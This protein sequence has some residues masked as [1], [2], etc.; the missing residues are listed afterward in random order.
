MTI[1]FRSVKVIKT[2]E[3]NDEAVELILELMHKNNR[4]AEEDELYQLLVLLVTNF[5]RKY[6]QP[7]ANFNPN[8]LLEFLREQKGIQEVDLVPILGSE[9]LVSDL[10]NG[11]RAINKKEANALGKFFNLDPLLFF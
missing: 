4:T 7:L 10:I 9:S 3:E 11:K 6:Y 8:S 5:E 2:E 1:D